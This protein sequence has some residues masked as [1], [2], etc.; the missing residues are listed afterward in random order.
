M[1]SNTQTKPFQYE[2]TP[3]FPVQGTLS[4]SYT[5]L[6]AHLITHNIHSIDGFVGVDWA[7]IIPKL[8]QEFEKQ[9]VTPR[10]IAM[11]S[12]LKT[13]SAIQELVAPYLGG[14]DP[15]FG[16]KAGIQLIEY[17]DTQ[18]LA[19]L[20]TIRAN[21]ESIQAEYTIFYGP[22]ASL[23]DTSSQLMFIDL[24]KN[25]LIQRMRAGEASNLGCS[26]QT[27]QKE[28]YK[29]YYFVDWEILNRHK[30]SILSRVEILAD[31]QSSQNL[32][33]I[34][35]KDL[36]ATLLA[37]SQNYFRVRPTFEPGVWGERAP[38]RHRSACQKL[39]VV[40]RNDC[41]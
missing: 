18:K 32:P 38:F 12:A 26:R 14:D 29:R 23:V 35:G 22:G 4:N 31:Q 1:Y 6:V 2:I 19:D 28:T 7:T 11:D 9:G 25:V 5:D 27:N 24:P 8:K 30:R 10:F 34:T 36:H 21:A 40:L 37:M 17:F 41:P 3:T 16:K 20:Q 39:C 13:E 15:L 33:W